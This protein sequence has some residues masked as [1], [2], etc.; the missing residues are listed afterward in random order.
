MFKINRFTLVSLLLVG[1]YL[2]SACGG[3]LPQSS[4]SEVAPKVLAK[5]IVFTGVVE[6]MNGS[7]WIVS[8]QKVTVDPAA[9]LYPNITV[10]MIVKVEGQVSADGAV[11][12][13]KVETSAV[14][15]DT[16]NDA[17]ANTDDGNANVNSNDDDSADDNANDDNSNDVGNSNDDSSNGN[18]N[19]ND[20]NG[21]DDNSN[22]AGDD[23]EGEVF[24][25]VEALTADSITIDGVTYQLAD[26]TKFE[27]VI[28]VGD[29]VEFHV[30]VNEDGTLT[31]RK[32]EKEDDLEDDDSDVEDRDDDDDDEI[33]GVVEVLT[34][35]SVTID[36]VTYLFTDFTKFDDVIVVGDQVEIDVI[37]NEDGT[38]TI[39]EIER[40]DD[41]GEDD[42]S[43]DDNANDD[44]SNDDNGNDDNS[45]DDNGNDDDDDN[46]NDD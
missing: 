26:F 32:I 31:I 24:G 42:N 9:A 23:D 43:N 46:G 40:S 30:I 4:A 16:T 12:A 19:S 33:S 18:V 34:A 35:D 6:A 39:R 14:T 11:T 8:G 41:L 37:V 13:L 20:D 45:N 7:E 3:T 22:D 29:Q 28:A 44:N 21:N 10:G 36:G 15:D 25:V 38:F 27:D 1:A 17:N 5:E 2:L